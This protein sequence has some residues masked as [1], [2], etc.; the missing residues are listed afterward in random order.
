MAGDRQSID[1][2]NN[3]DLLRLA[4]NVQ[5]SREPIL[6]VSQDQPLAEVRPAR[7]QRQKASKSVSTRA[8]RAARANEWLLRLIDIGADAVSADAATDVSTNK[9]KYL[10]EAYRAASRRQRGDE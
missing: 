1:V 8:T 6:L 5:R 4:E 9:H 10:A 3:P 7:S 2:S